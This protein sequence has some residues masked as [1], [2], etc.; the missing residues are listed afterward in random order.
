MVEFLIASMFAHAE[1]DEHGND[2]T[3]SK[4][5]QEKL[6]AYQTWFKRDQSTRYILLSCM[7][8]DLLGEIEGCLTAKDMWDRLKIR[9][10]QTSAIRLHT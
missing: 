7:H 3:A 1:R 5:Y 2:V 9:F 4:Q 8:D 10:D 6:K